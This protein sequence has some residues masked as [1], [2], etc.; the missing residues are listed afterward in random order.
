MPQD[1]NNVAPGFTTAEM[2]SAIAKLLKQGVQMARS[3][4]KCLVMAVYD[5]IANESAVVANALIG[6]LR[7]STKR[8]GIIAFLEQFGQLHDKGGKKGFVHFALGAQA[9][10]AWTKEYVETVQDAAMTWEA[11]KPAAAAP[12]AFDV[13]KAVESVIKKAGKANE[14]DGPGCIDG[15]L[16]EYLNALL[17]QYTARKA[18]A[19]AQETA[20]DFATE[21]RSAEAAT[22]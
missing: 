20:K 8:Q 12:E 10:L 1:T 15:E 4:E 6:A 11:F 21:I 13:V 5:S 7:I 17:G 14:P 22:N 18:L 9:R 16:V 3:V 19:K 2:E